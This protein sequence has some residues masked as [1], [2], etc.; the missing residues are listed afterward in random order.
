VAAG[1]VP[2]GGY[3]GRERSEVFEADDW[4]GRAISSTSTTAALLLPR[5]ARRDD[6][7][8]GAN[9]S[10]GRSRRLS[11]KP[12]ACEAHVVGLDDDRSVS[13]SRPRSSPRNRSTWSADAPLR[14]QLSSYKMPKDLLV[15][16]EEDVPMM[17]SG[18]LD[19]L[20]LK[21]LFDGR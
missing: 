1:S 20:A 14:E 15:L 13:G 6:Q 10:P 4:F 11:P 12:P 18:K 3:Y 2:D 16:A 5:P 9:V 7:A 17:S 19:L 8:T 21:A